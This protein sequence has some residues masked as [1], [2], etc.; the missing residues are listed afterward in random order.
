[1]LPD[2]QMCFFLSGTRKRSEGTDEKITSERKRDQIPAGPRI[3][4]TGNYCL[5]LKEEISLGLNRIIIS[6]CTRFCPIKYIS[7]VYNLK[8]WYEL[9]S[10]CSVLFSLLFVFIIA[11]DWLETANSSS[12]NFYLWKKS[13]LFFIFWISYSQQCLDWV[14]G[15]TKYHKP[16]KNKKC[17]KLFCRKKSG[18]EIFNSLFSQLLPLFLED[19]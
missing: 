12:Y 5:H 16:L 7:N 4:K 18:L 19:F 1:M 8:I 10:Q 15:M 17:E 11:N 3:L 9:S 6:L 13:L 2:I 14:A